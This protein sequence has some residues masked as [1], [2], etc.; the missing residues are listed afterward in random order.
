MSTCF[1]HLLSRLTFL[2]CLDWH[3]NFVIYSV[4]ADKMQHPF[5][6]SSAF[7]RSMLS[8]RSS[9]AESCASVGKKKYIQ[10]CVKT[11]SVN[12]GKTTTPSWLKLYGFKL[13]MLEL[14]GGQVTLGT[15]WEK[16]QKHVLAYT[17]H[18]HAVSLTHTL[19]ISLL[20]NLYRG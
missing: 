6:Y 2:H 15:N 4:F 11:L 14:K 20:W 1:V 3:T 16:W 12:H 9:M 8:M 10:K 7:V 13:R 18:T 5:T 17:L 19:N